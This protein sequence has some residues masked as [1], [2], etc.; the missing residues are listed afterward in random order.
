MHGRVIGDAV[1]SHVVDV[2][3]KML[4]SADVLFRHQDDEFVALLFQ[5]PEATAL[6]IASRLHEAIQGSRKELAVSVSV[7]VAVASAPHDG[8]S[9]DQLLQVARGRLIKPS[10]NGYP[11]SSSEDRI[12]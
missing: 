10:G 2:T 7:T 9:F 3:R 5:T 11:H 4:R 12:H 6:A 8:E 1:L